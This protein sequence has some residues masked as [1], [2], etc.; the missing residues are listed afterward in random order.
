MVR[1]LHAFSCRIDWFVCYFFFILDET[2]GKVISI[3]LEEIYINRFQE[4]EGFILKEVETFDISNSSSFLRFNFGIAKCEGKVSIPKWH[5]MPMTVC[6]YELHFGVDIS[7][8]RVCPVEVSTGLCDIMVSN[9][10]K[11]KRIFANQKA[12]WLLQL[13]TLWCFCCMHTIVCM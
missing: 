8:F 10:Q 13:W 2:E 5:Q 7:I 1:Y 12:R 9:D 3:N 6:K 4:I 11:F